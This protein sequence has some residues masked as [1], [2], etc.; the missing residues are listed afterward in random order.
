MPFP[1]IIMT[2]AKR[3]NW[4]YRSWV[5]GERKITS[6]CIA[7]EIEVEEKKGVSIYLI[8]LL[9][10]GARLLRTTLNADIEVVRTWPAEP[11]WPTRYTQLRL[12]RTMISIPDK[13]APTNV[14]VLSGPLCTTYSV[15][16]I[17]WAPHKMVFL[18]HRSIYFG[19][20][21]VI[22]ANWITL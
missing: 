7:I 22:K 15:A 11:V 14:S 8:N 4:S 21:F 9:Y 6:T 19:F 18:A 20:C 16:Q 5:K 2:S 12:Y 10:R 17:L 1:F 13:N 3:E